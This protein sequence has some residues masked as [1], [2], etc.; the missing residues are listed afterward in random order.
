MV[1]I[2]IQKM[3]QATG[4]MLA[5]MWLQIAGVLF[6]FVFDP[7]LIFGIG[8]FPEMG[9]AGAALATVLGYTLSMVIALIQLFFTK[10]KVKSLGVSGIQSRLERRLVAVYKFEKGIHGIPV[11]ILNGVLYRRAKRSGKTHGID[12]RVPDIRSENYLSVFTSLIRLNLN[13][14]SRTGIDRRDISSEFC[15]SR[16]RNGPIGSVGRGKPPADTGNGRQT[17]FSSPDSSSDIGNG[18]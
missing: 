9:I 13:F 4:N 6:N 1:H 18:G 11:V 5:P 15:P 3:L 14:P 8:P 16:G 12:I 17:S 2:A 10:Q 7:L